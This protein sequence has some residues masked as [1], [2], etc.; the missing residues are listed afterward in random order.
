[1]AASEI[2]NAKASFVHIPN[3]IIVA[4]GEANTMQKTRFVRSG[5]RIALTKLHQVH[6]I[7]RD[8]LHDKMGAEAGAEA[9]TKL[10]RAPP[11]YPLILRCALAFICSSIICVLGFGGCFVDMFISGACASF[12]QYLGLNAAAKS[13][14]YA[15]VYEFVFAPVFFVLFITDRCW[16]RISVSIIVSFVARGLSSIPGNLFCYNAISS[17]GVVLILPGFTICKFADLIELV[18]TFKALVSSDQLPRNNIK[19]YP[20]WLSSNGLCNHIHSILGRC[21]NLTWALSVS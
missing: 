5:G 13:S 2:L 4:L 10:L 6:E 8:V 12:L 19:K 11:I 3:I 21:K 9:L 1:V 18:R 14:M 17:A 15:N 7:Y 16:L 20:V